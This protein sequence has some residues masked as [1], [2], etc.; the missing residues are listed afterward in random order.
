VFAKKHTKLPSLS[1]DDA[2]EEALCFGW[3]D[4]LLRSIDDR[5]HMQMFTPR[6]AKSMW[7]ATNR[8]R[9]ARLARAGLMTAT[10]KAAV[11][12]A[13]KLGTWTG[14]AEAEQLIVPPELARAI[15][16]DP[17]ARTHWPAYSAS[18]RKTF[19]YVLNSAKRPETR[20]RRIQAIVDVVSR[21]VS[22]TEL[23]RRAM[24]GKRAGP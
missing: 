10:G 23:R 8:A 9:V 21:N 19:L 4:S 6:K 2:V 14:R 12:Q 1:Y 15:R 18:A 13:R 24:A 16:A 17:N 7:S 22:M 20:A 11:A 3:I 5:F